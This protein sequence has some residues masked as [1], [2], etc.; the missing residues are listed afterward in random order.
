MKT[1]FRC[2]EEKEL[3]E[4]YKHKEMGDGY[5]GKCKKCTKGDTKKAAEE[6]KND[7]AW[8]ERERTRGR[9]KYHRLKYNHSARERRNT[10]E[11]KARAS[12]SS[13]RYK[14]KYPEKVE[15][16]I[17]SQRVPKKEGYEKHHWSYNKEHQKDII[18][19]TRAEHSLAHRMTMYDQERK[20]YRRVDNMELLD[21]RVD[22]LKFLEALFIIS[23]DNFNKG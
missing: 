8:V 9:E 22:Y 13:K 3:S 7:P 20:M 23:V 17:R 16:T 5:L 15:A 1:C 10:D 19:L 12:I 11:G 6:K 18:Y 2:G 21:N 14:D 4:F